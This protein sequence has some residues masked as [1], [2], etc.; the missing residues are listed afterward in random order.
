MT[1]RW[2]PMALRDLPTLNTRGRAEIELESRRLD[3]LPILERWSGP[4]R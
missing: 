1:A 3:N 4:I 2:L